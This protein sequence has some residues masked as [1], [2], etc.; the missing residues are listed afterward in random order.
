MQSGDLHSPQSY[1]N[2]LVYGVLYPVLSAN[3]INDDNY[4]A[5]Q[6]LLRQ[7]LL[8]VRVVLR[9]VLFTCRRLAD[10]GAAAS[11]VAEPAAVLADH[12]P[13]FVGVVTANRRRVAVATDPTAR[14]T[15]RHVSTPD[16]CIVSPQTTHNAFCS[17]S[18]RL[19]RSV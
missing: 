18:R 11:D 3:P 8:R 15:S 14:H 16:R 5:Q 13:R 2:F 6:Q 12:V 17:A 4:I 1:P 7:P 9:L 10:A 19:M